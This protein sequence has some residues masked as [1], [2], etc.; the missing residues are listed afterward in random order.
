VRFKKKATLDG[1]NGDNI[2]NVH[3]ANLPA[4][5]TLTHFHVNMV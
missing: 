5:P 4:L 1:Q 3:V 2:A